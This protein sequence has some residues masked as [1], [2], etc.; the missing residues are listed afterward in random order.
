VPLSLGTEL[1]LQARRSFCAAPGFRGRFDFG[2]DGATPGDDGVAT[3]GGAGRVT[4]PAARRAD[5]R[6]A[7][8]LTVVGVLV[9]DGVDEDRA[10]AAA[11]G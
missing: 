8:R 11:L 1:L 3:D 9:G 6:Y 4:D 2:G 10:R 7:L 5:R